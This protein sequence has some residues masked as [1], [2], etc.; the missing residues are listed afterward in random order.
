MS[1]N[2]ALSYAEREGLMQVPMPRTRV[3]R[4]L[5]LH[6]LPAIWWF[7]L[8]AIAAYILIAGAYAYYS[9]QGKRCFLLLLLPA[10][11]YIFVITCLHIWPQ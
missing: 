7:P 1:L 5:I 3:L 11:N 10:I 9:L 2:F 4:E 6:S 8:L